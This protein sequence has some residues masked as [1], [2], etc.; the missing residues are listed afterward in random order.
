MFQS[1]P[2]KALKNWRCQPLEISWTMDVQN[3]EIFQ[4]E[5]WRWTDWTAVPSASLFFGASPGAKL[6]AWLKISKVYPVRFCTLSSGGLSFNIHPPIL[7][8]TYS[9]QGCGGF[10]RQPFTLPP[11]QWFN[12]S[13]MF[14]VCP[15]GISVGTLL[16][17]SSPLSVLGTPRLTVGMEAS[18]TSL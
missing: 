5:A 6:Q 18:R 15:E 13:N 10:R 7:K 8:Q 4:S 11:A 14:P 3:D 9:G 12:P 2:H 1:N 17:I 16:L